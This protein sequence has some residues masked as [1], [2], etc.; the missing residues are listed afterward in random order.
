MK[1]VF[2]ISTALLALALSA[3]PVMLKVGSYNLRTNVPR[4]L[5]HNGWK[6]RAPRCIAFLKSAKFDIF[7][8]QEVQKCHIKTI[9]SIGY[10]AIGQPRDDKENSEYSAIFYDPE[11]LELNKTETFWLSETPD[12]PG[13]RSWNSAY[14][15]ICTVGYFTHK[16]SGKNFLFVNTH[17]DHKSQLARENAIRMIISY[18]KKFKKDHPY[19]LT[20]DFNARPDSEVYKEISGFMADAR[21]VS[22]KVL[23]GPNQTFHGYQAD[24]AKRRMN[25]PIDYIFVNDVAVKVKTFQ[26]IDDFKNGFASSDHFPVAATV[27]FQ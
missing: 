13:S 26:V 1:K 27:I 6:S 14:P 24:P 18:L 3:A 2:I 23:P 8:T 16:A 19:I 12:V 21:T 7:G 10:K 20:G 22:E 25:M 4:D 5:P 15:R 11:I 9:T 17:L